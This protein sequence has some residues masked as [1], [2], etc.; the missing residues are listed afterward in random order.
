MSGVAVPGKGLEEEQ[1]KISTQDLQSS[2]Q[3]S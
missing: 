1:N 3:D 2:P